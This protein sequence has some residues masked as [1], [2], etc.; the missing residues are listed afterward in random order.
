M[1][2]GSVEEFESLLKDTIRCE[3]DTINQELQA[4][5]GSLSFVTKWENLWTAQGLSCHNKLKILKKIR[6]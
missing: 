3:H 4:I 6:G 5:A 1:E 2:Q